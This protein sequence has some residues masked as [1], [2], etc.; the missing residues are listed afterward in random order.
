[1]PGSGPAGFVAAGSAGAPLPRVNVT[2]RDTP[3]SLS[4]RLRT[5]VPAPL[6]ANVLSLPWRAVGGRCS[7]GKQGIDVTAQAF[8]LCTVVANGDRWA[9]YRLSVSFAGRAGTTAIIELRASRAGAIEIAVGA[10]TV[11]VKERIGDTWHRL[12]RLRVPPPAENA[13]APAAKPPPSLIGGGTV[14]L[15]ITLHAS[16]LSLSL[17]VRPASARPGETRLAADDSIRISEP[18]AVQV[19]DGVI[20]FGMV[21]PGTPATVA[22]RQVTTVSAP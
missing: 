19:R 1:R 18:L 7:V 6:P 4:V 11:S 8:A 5:G 22:F 16:E 2:A 9:N 13:S 14:Q 20:A 10:S 17:R 3:A 21:G 15:S 12:Q